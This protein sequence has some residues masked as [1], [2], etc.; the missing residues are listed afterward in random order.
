MKP[1]NRHKN[2]AGMGNR[3]SKWIPLSTAQETFWIMWT[4]G[5]PGIAPAVRCPSATIRADE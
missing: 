1:R 4:H 3:E 2:S 5:Y